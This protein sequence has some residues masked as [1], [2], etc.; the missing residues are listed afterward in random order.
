MNDGQQPNGRA[1]MQ[2]IIDRYE[3]PL[4]G[5]AARITGDME[6]ARAVVQEVFL[7]L[8]REDAIQRNGY[9]PQWLFTVCRNKA[10]DVYRKNQRLWV[11]GDE[12]MEVGTSPDVDPSNIVESQEGTGR[13]GEMLTTL[14]SNQQEV[15][16]LR[17]QHGLSYKEIAGVTKLSVT[18]VGFLIHTAIKTIRDRLGAGER[19]MPR[20]KT[21]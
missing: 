9:L 4:T 21:I 1:R 16:R 12:A 11:V 19:S 8:C 18:N 20:E 17:F 15:I 10:L 6:S 5:Y 2:S 13:I 3:G 7:S 14:P